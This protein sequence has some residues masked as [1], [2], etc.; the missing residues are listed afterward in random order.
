[1]I[2][3]QMLIGPHAGLGRVH[4]ERS[5]TFGRSADCDIVIDAP[6]P[7]HA[8]PHL[9]RR[10]GELRLGDGWWVLINRSAN[11]TQIN[12]RRITDDRPHPLKT[13]DVVRVA[14]TKLFA[15]H[16]TP[17]DLAAEPNQADV[18]SPADETGEAESDVRAPRPPLSGR[19]KL[20]IGIGVFN[21]AVLITIIIFATA[22][23]GGPGA[24]EP[25]EPLTEQQIAA[26]IRQPVQ[27]PLDEREA[28]RHLA[29]A[30]ELYSSAG[31]TPGSLYETHR[32]YQLA[33]AYSGGGGGAGGGGAVG[34]ERGLRG[35]DRLRF[36]ETQRRLIERVATLY[37]RAY[38]RL[39]NREWLAA[40]RLLRELT[41]AY[42]DTNSVIFE[43]VQAQLA[44]A[45]ANRPQ[46]RGFR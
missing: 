33:L 28:A 46:R 19:A 37:R 25:V 24:V 9:S 31:S 13:G 32:H 26:A 14:G 20:W 27:R 16:F 45:L 10:H 22:G 42:P 5:L 44:V 17:E 21:L 29:E 41:E 30:R 3:I 23:G 12:R 7:P 34:G 40:E 11:G 18:D 4:E 36:Q 43:N 2:R 15:V 8:I 39:R 1:M 38:A 6:H 35:L